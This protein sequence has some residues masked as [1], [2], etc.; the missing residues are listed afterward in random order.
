V[1]ACPPSAWYR[2]RK[3]ARRNKLGLTVTTGVV[4]VALVTLVTL[5]VS[6]VLIRREQART[7]GEKVRAEKAQRLAEEGAAEVR[8]GLERLQEANALVD[9]GRSYMNWQRW[10]DAHAAL[11]RAIEL[12][13]DHALAWEER[14]DLYNRL[15]LWELAA[16]DLG[17]AFELQEPA[18]AW[19]WYSLALLRASAGEMTG[20]RAFTKRMFE[21]FHGTVDRGLVMDLVKTS[22][23]GDVGFYRRVCSTMLEQFGETQDP[24]SGYAVVAACGL[25]PD[26]LPDMARL[27]PVGRVAARWDTGGK[28]MLAVASYRAGEDEEAVR[29]F[30]EAAKLYH[31]R[32]EDWL[33][34]AMAHHKSGRSGEAQ[35][36]LARGLEWVRDAD[37]QGPSDLAGTQPAWADWHE[38]VVVETLLREAEALVRETKARPAPTER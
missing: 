20:H 10:D 28:R 4:S 8:R 14:G 11:T 35:R 19:R 36:C 13:P 16:A 22:A 26:A 31:L 34:L 29:C 32:G 37:R 38:R 25:C 5:S 2:F 9:R 33:F 7:K 17:K 21:R 15:H 12:R 18:Q 24:R 3:F 23:A 1:Q 30:Q 6:N 27:V